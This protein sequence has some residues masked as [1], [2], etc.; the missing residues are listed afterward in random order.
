V[1]NGSAEPESDPRLAYYTAVDLVKL[2]SQEVYSRFAA[3]LTLHGPIFAAIGVS[4]GRS[5][6]HPVPEVIA[7]GLS[8]A[9]FV[10]C[11]PWWWFVDHGLRPVE[12]L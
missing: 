8:V 12:V 1:S 9:G 3:M 10:L 5:N 11:L 2:V 7:L 6:Y 4:L